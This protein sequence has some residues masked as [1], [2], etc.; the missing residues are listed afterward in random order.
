MSI[1][2]ANQKKQLPQHIKEQFKVATIKLDVILKVMQDIEQKFYTNMLKL[3]EIVFGKEKEYLT[4]RILTDSQK[5]ELL[6]IIEKDG[7]E[8]KEEINQI[9]TK[10]LTDLKAN[11]KNKKKKTN[12]RYQ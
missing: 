2:K 6:M 8:I 1:L 9:I 11:Q 7:T 10:Y 4:T 3:E 12:K 5:K